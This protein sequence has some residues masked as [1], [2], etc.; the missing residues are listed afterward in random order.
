MIT[1]NPNEKQEKRKPAEMV[2]FI[3]ENTEPEVKPEIKKEISILGERSIVDLHN[4][5]TVL[6]LKIING[7]DKFNELY[8]SLSLRQSYIDSIPDVPFILNS[9]L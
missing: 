1:N 4:E 8:K 9:A 6:C 3:S 7:E 5:I 2:S